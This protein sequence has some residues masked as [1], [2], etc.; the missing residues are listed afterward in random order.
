MDK[1]KTHHN[2]FI[3]W[4][5]KSK[6]K[7]T[8]TYGYHLKNARKIFHLNNTQEVTIAIQDIEKYIKDKSFSTINVK[9]KDIRNWK[10]ALMK[11]NLFLTAFNSTM[12]PK[13]YPENILVTDFDLTMQNFIE[14]L[15]NV[16]SSSSSEELMH[17]KAGKNTEQRKIV[18]EL[19]RNL[20][21]NLSAKFTNI[22]WVSEKKNSN[23][24]DSIDLYGKL[25]S[26]QKSINII[27]EF[28]SSRADQIAKKFVSRVANLITES[29]IYIAFC[30][31]GT[32]NMSK[33]E[34]HK[35][36]VNC[37]SIMTQ[38]STKENPKLFIGMSIG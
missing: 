3:T 23:N 34:A 17:I 27:I 26:N 7:S 30:Y 38:L 32:E 37:H 14:E 11:Y 21:E 24:K 18:M 33:P 16:V 20:L 2:A 35:Y 29:C 25:D 13:Q 28:D 31:P 19:Q 8:N 9:E 12:I 5:K 15:V 22:E 1:E 36:F 4:M 10:S 6:F